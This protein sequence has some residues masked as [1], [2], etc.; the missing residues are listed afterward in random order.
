M[1]AQAKTTRLTSLIAVL[2]ISYLAQYVSSKI[3]DFLY[4]RLISQMQQAC[5]VWVVNLT[6]FRTH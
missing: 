4:Y 2:S 3:Y 6:Q 1:I 5:S